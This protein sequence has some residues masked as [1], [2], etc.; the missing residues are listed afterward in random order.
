MR[1][2]IKSDG[3]EYD[4]YDLVYVGNVLVISCVPTKTIEVIKCVLK[5]KGNKIEPP[6]I[7][8]G[9]SLQQV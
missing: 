8:L 1:P 7:Y 2:E 4:E 5:L 6:N 9:A 3:T